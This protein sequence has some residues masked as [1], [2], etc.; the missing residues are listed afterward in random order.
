MSTE[1]LSLV[2]LDLPLAMREGKV[3]RLSPGA[4][5]LSRSRQLRAQRIDLLPGL[6]ESI[7][8]SVSTAIVPRLAGADDHSLESLQRIDRGVVDRLGGCGSE[9]SLTALPPSPAS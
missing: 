8:V 4:T 5:A 6:P 2:P 9:T 3:V 7:T 1:Q